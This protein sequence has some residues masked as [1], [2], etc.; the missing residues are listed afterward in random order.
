VLYAELYTT[1]HTSYFPRN[2]VLM[3]RSTQ[4]K[5]IKIHKMQ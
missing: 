2:R 1:T 4:H 3:L 5:F